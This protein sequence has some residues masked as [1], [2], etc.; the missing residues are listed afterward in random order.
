MSQQ[1]TL[2]TPKIEIY[3]IA[4][5]EETYQNKEDGY[6]VLDNRNNERSDWREYWPIRKFFQN[7]KIED[8]TYYGFFSP[9]FREK[10]FLSYDQVRGFI[11]DNHDGV[12][13]VGFS[14]Q[15]D[16]GALFLNV[17]EG[18]DL[19][20]SGFLDVSQKFVEH[21]GLSIELRGFIMD[22]RSIIFSNYFVARGSFWRS[23]VR[24]ADQLFDIAEGHVPSTIRDDLTAATNYPGAVPRKV[25]LMERLVS[26]L[27]ITGNWRVVNSN[28]FKLAWSSH[29]Q[30]LMLDTFLSDA[31][32][33]A[34]NETGYGEFL[35]AYNE[36]RKK[37]FNM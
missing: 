30:H 33:I 8:D 23:W 20:D 1:S 19:F 27:I 14:P 2:D 6:L 3:H 5:S 11:L 37:A 9:R 31:L 28:P 10:T 25:F 7:H 24:M 34:Y 13:V 21:V 22:S 32:K 16:I 17:F 15:P 36:I 26:L 4:Y 29:F 35:F 18:N 12:D